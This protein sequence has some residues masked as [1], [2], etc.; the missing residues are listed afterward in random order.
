MPF[1]R[2]PP[3]QKVAKA[4]GDD[5]DDEATGDAAALAASLIA[6]K[7][8]NA[9]PAT[10]PR[11]ASRLASSAGSPSNMPAASSAPALSYKRARSSV[12]E[13]FCSPA[14]G[15][16]A[17]PAR[18]IEE[19]IARLRLDR[20]LGGWTK[21]GPERRWAQKWYDD[22]SAHDIGCEMLRSH[23]EAVD[24]ALAMA[25]GASVRMAT[26]VL[27][28]HVAVLRIHQVDY[29]TKLKTDLVERRLLA[30]L[31]RPT[32][33][34]AVA[35]LLHI[36]SPW[37]VTAPESDEPEAFDPIEAR[38]CCVE[39]SPE[40]KAK[41]FKDCLIKRILAPTVREGE[42][43]V[44]QCTSLVTQ[45]IAF[46]EGADDID[47]A[48]GETIFEL[49]RL[50]RL[51]ASIIHQNLVPATSQADVAWLRQQTASKSVEKVGAIMATVILQVPFYADKFVELETFGAGTAMYQEKINDVLSQLDGAKKLPAILQ[52][53]AVRDGLQAFAQV[54]GRVMPGMALDL[55]NKVEIAIDIMIAA[56]RDELRL[57][58][59][60]SLV[61]VVL[62]LLSEAERLFGAA[63]SRTCMQDE[64]AHGLQEH[65]D[66]IEFE[67]LQ[68]LA[69]D[70]DASISAGEALTDEQR[71]SIFEKL[72]RCKPMASDGKCSTLTK[73]ATSLANSLCKHDLG[74]LALRAG[75]ISLLSALSLWC[76]TVTVDD[77]QLSAGIAAQVLEL[78]SKVH[79]T[80]QS[81]QSA[82]L[83]IADM[84]DSQVTEARAAAE[85][86]ALQATD[87]DG[88]ALAP[89]IKAAQAF[90]KDILQKV[91]TEHLASVEKSI[92]DLYTGTLRDMEGGGDSGA[93]WS[94]GLSDGATFKTVYTQA[95]KQL[96]AKKPK[97]LTT[98]TQ[99]LKSLCDRYI[100]LQGLHSH[101]LEDAF[102]WPKWFVTATDGVRRAQATI[103]SGLI[104]TQMAQTHTNP[105]KLQN[106]SKTQIKLLEAPLYG[107]PVKGLIHP[108][109]LRA[110][111]AASGKRFV[112]PA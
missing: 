11:L 72:E 42:V 92:K 58:H 15:E 70:I 6:A 84:E 19:H 89:P 2:P 63:P 38:M 24:A 60:D 105:L 48:Y 53:D 62:P 74:A 20:I 101:P 64:L 55:R 85:Q 27:Q 41:E 30:W 88:T 12:A 107:S 65:A 87:L 8:D 112:W 1:P 77:S 35:E 7:G 17:R 14:T 91:K 29:P 39:G 59:S 46:L 108:A 47:E 3:I 73:L 40:E 94:K 36:I 95:L 66:R 86:L 90:A 71:A 10:P 82:A 104:L 76:K 9:P 23:L 33:F 111:E 69:H 98:V 44:S 100:S 13:S 52:G 45:V 56:A 81:L 96:L 18:S 78:V 79:A 93:L 61:G 75:D 80:C 34:E 99:R 50:Y 68:A 37:A 109:I 4:W 83:A 16:K 54:D 110:A 31:S 102:V 51:V 97:E 5:I 26:D 22:H 32:R 28:R 49:L 103:S 106:M 67:N 43:Q 21:I 25:G 57:A